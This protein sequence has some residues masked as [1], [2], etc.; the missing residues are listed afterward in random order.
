METTKRRMGEARPEAIEG[1]I[2]RLRTE[3]GLVVHEIER[4]AR[5]ATSMR[6]QAR[7]H[8]LVT[9]GVVAALAGMTV[10]AIAY[11]IHRRRLRQRRSRLKNLRIAI[12]H[13]MAHPEDVMDHRRARAKEKLLSAGTSVGVFG[14]KRLLRR[15]LG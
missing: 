6:L 12:A 13:L 1:D 7:R 15:L 4:R 5:E 11:P 9:F 8:P 3:L 10:F 2:A 14:A